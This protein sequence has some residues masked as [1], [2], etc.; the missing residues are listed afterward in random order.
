MFKQDRYAQILSILQTRKSV[1]VNYLVKELYV[2]PATVRR[3]LAALAEQGVIKHYYG[4]ATLI[5]DPS[6]AA[7]IELRHFENHAAKMKIGLKALSLISNGDSL[8][9]DAS[10]TCLCMVPGLQQFENLT[11]VTNSQRVLELLAETSIVTYSIGGKLLRNSMAFTGRIAEE[12]LREMHF[13]KCFFSCQALSKDGILSDGGEAE[14]QIHRILINKH[15][16]KIVLCDQSKLGHSCLFS[17]GSIEQIDYI[18]SDTDIFQYVAEPLDS[19]PIM[20][21]SE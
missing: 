16:K 21:Q 5:Q 9:I 6:K 18:I 14:N 17:I 19:K 20:L 1:T 8:F 11:V 7:P 15:G 12:C 2:S 4:G 10:S 3:D 13:D